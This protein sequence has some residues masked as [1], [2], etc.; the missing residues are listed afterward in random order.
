MQRKERS[1][2]LVTPVDQYETNRV[3]NGS[4]F[5]AANSDGELYPLVIGP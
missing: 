2:V 4:Q 3:D 1:M 5:E